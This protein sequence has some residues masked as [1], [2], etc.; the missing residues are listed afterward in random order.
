MATE[1]KDPSTGNDS[2]SLQTAIDRAT[3]DG[4]LLDNDKKKIEMWEVRFNIAKAICVGLF[5]ILVSCYSY[6]KKLEAMEL[7]DHATKQVQIE[8]KAKE[9]AIELKEELQSEKRQEVAVLKDAL[10]ESTQNAT[11]SKKQALTLVYFQF[12]GTTT[13]KS[14]NEFCAKLKE[15]NYNAP[16]G[17]R[18]DFDFKNAVKYFD[19]SQL[20]P[21]K[22][23]ATAASELLASYNIHATFEVKQVSG[24][25]GSPLELWVADS[26]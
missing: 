12:G 11:A 16:G 3:L 17:E 6:L 5:G 14:V 1:S 9:V 19:E 23:L 26:F 18:I 21:A 15:R 2:P 7:A 20:E 25:V 13:R 4:L 8:K 24:K 10:T 22:Q